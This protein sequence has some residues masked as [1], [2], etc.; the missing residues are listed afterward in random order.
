VQIVGIA[1]TFIGIIIVGF[2]PFLHDIENQISHTGHPT[3]SGSGN[4]PNWHRSMLGVL[5]ALGVRVLQSV[6]FAA[7][8]RFM[9]TGKFVPMQQVLS[10]LVVLWKIC[11][12]AFSMFRPWFCILTH[13]FSFK[14]HPEGWDGRGY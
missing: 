8:E 7:E 12:Q 11:A 9:K 14:L 1:I 13:Y 6:Q 3:K 5:I 10:I 2:F 4:D